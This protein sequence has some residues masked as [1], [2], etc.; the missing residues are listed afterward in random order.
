MEFRLK[1]LVIF[2]YQPLPQLAVFDI[3]L[4]GPMSILYAGYGFMTF[5]YFF[6][7]P[8][9]YHTGTD[10]ESTLMQCSK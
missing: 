9:K 1:I 6:T 4:G 8:I 7:K 2:N 3:D 5:S 10:F